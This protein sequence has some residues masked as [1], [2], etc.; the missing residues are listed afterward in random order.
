MHQVTYFC[1]GFAKNQHDCFVVTMSIVFSDLCHAPPPTHPTKEEE[2]SGEKHTFYI[3]IYYMF[4]AF[5]TLTSWA[6]K[7]MAYPR[8]TVRH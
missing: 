2:K 1:C 6:V 3:N 4:E 5:G 7:A 8:R